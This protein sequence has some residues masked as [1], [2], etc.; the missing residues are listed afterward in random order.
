M[1]VVI[2]DREVASYEGFDFGN[3]GKDPEGIEIK[4]AVRLELKIDS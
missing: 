4:R 3:E 1:S 2:P